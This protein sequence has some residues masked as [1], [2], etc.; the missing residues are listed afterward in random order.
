VVVAALA[1]I[2]LVLGGLIY[3]DVFIG[4]KSAGA[5]LNLYTVARRTVTASVTGT[6]N[7][8]PM[9]QANV[10]FKV[11]GSLTAIYVR[12]GDR[13]HTGEVLARIDPAPEQQ[14][15]ASAQA[16][17]AMAEANLQSAVTPLTPAQ[18]GQLQ[19]N[20]D[21][22]QQSYN[23]TVA[24]VG[25]TNTQDAAQVA[26]DQSQ[27]SSDTLAYNTNAVD[28]DDLARL[29]LDKQTLGTA[30]ATWNADLATI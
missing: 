13:V 8:V 10:S 16:N 28:Q 19:H 7:L 26:S 14:A 9:G 1:A 15:L 27:L 20:L 18:A 3:R 29:T 24:Q 12:V 11:S 6:G 4:T 30:Q 5:T 17:L 22:A 25:T 23:D 2:A 21:M